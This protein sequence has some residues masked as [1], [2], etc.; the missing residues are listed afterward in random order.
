[1]RTRLC[2][3]ADLDS[4]A[5]GATHGKVGRVALDAEGEARLAGRPPF[6]SI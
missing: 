6:K 5:I 1:V 3:G 4:Y 2:C